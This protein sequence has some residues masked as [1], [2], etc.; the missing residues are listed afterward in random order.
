[1]GN[2]GN[3]SSRRVDITLDGL[4]IDAQNTLN[5]DAVWVG[6]TSN[7]T[8]KN[9]QVGN[10]MA[11]S[12]SSDTAKSVMTCA[13]NSTCHNIN[14]VFE[15]NLFYDAD[16]ASGS[17]AHL[18]CIWAGGVQGFTL[19]RNTFR[20]CTYFDVFVTV[21]LVNGQPQPKDHLF[22]NNL[23]GQTVNTSGGDGGFTLSL[24]GDVS[25]DNFDYRSDS[26]GG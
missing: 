12:G 1:V 4:N 26:S 23:F 14:M 16:T 3:S 9:S 6:N 17:A 24:H 13:G 18:E 5:T 8:I 22:E 11:G 20:D 19:R 15:N 10:T 7:F 21:V 2:S 25:P